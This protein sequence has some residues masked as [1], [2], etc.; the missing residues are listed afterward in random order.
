M[1]PL[2][3]LFTVGHECRV[4]YKFE[5]QKRL[6]VW[7]VPGMDSDARCVGNWTFVK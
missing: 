7:S 5:M 2:N 1:R 3:V 4:V 6:R